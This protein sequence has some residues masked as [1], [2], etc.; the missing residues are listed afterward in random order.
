MTTSCNGASSTRGT[1]SLNWV[2]GS[3]SLA[4]ATVNRGTKR[5]AENVC[6]SVGV[7]IADHMSF[8]TAF[9]CWLDSLGSVGLIVD[10]L[11]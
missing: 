6:G 7:D 8:M 10:G 3:M 1:R 4:L 5:L 9:C 11:L 2:Y